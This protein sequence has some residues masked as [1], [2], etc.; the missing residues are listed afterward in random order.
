VHIIIGIAAGVALLYF[1]LLGH[2]FARVLVHLMLMPLLAGLLAAAFT[3]GVGHPGDPIGIIGGCILGLTAGWFIASAP[4]YYWRHKLRPIYEAAYQWELRKQQMLSQKG[5]TQRVDH[6]P[7][8]PEWKLFTICCV[9]CC[10][11]ALPLLVILVRL[12]YS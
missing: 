9:V 11:V 6:E 10:A 4:V 2:W 8:E 7:P 1:W 5:P 12:T 3:V